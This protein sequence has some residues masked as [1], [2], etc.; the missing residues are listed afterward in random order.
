MSSVTFIWALVLGACVTMALPHL[1]VGVKQRAWENLLFTVAALGVAGIAFGEL[2]IMHSR[3]PAEIGRAVQ[4]THVP[5]F[6]I[7]VGIIGFVGTYFGTGR[8]WL[9]ITAI[10]ARLVSLTLNFAFPPNLNFREITGLRHLDFLGDTVA[11]PEGASNPW[12]RLG[13]L[14]SLLMLA[15]VIDASIALWRRGGTE[16]RRRA[17]IVGGSVT[18]FIL[19]AAGSRP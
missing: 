6:M 10:G 18:L 8:R 11:M 14:S 19:I 7:Y 2:H 5:L 16:N 12:T 1:L 15:F 17:A 9:G 3:T 13:E 4:W